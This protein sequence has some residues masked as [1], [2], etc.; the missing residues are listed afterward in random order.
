MKKKL[1]YVVAAVIT[2]WFVS[3]I[4]SD[5]K[6]KMMKIVEGNP[7][8]SAD[9]VYDKLRIDISM[10]EEIGGA[11]NFKYSI[12]DEKI[13]QV[14]FRYLGR[15]YYLQATREDVPMEEMGFFEKDDGSWGGTTLSVG[16]DAGMTGISWEDI[17][18]GGSVVCWGWNG[19][20]FY[21]VSSKAGEDCSSYLAYR[22]GEDSYFANRWLYGSRQ[23]SNYI[24]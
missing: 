8:E 13:G 20:I 24:Y 14:C 12:I 6:M 21:L 22:I 10:P 1:A 2:L 18:G 15:K 3:C 19:V 17:K 16:G 5:V 7:V 23:K 4:Y 9:V 11:S